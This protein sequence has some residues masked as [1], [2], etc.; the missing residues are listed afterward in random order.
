MGGQHGEGWGG[1]SDIGD[2]EI[3]D[4]GGEFVMVLV[5]QIEPPKMDTAGE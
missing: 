3:L 2:N 4:I 1:I 5:D